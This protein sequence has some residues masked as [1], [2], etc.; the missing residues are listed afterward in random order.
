MAGPLPTPP[1]DGRRHSSSR[2]G[3]S[4][5][6]PLHYEAWRVR[7]DVGLMSAYA[8]GTGDQGAVEVATD[9]PVWRYEASIRFPAD[10]P[11]AERWASR[12]R[13]S[14]WP[15]S[16]HHRTVL[17]IARTVG[18]PNPED[19]DCLCDLLDL[20]SIHSRFGDAPDGRR[21]IGSTRPGG[22]DGSTAAPREQPC[23]TDLPARR[24]PR[25]RGDGDARR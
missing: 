2:R 16:T 22:E 8:A 10:P 7:G 20:E 19:G 24:G 5:S 12:A 14:S 11:E 4:N 9:E 25:Q 13:G 6:R 18:R 3:D 21:Q 23:M 1:P 17:R 15:S